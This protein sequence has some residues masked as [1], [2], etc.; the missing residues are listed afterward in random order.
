MEA[1]FGIGAFVVMFGMW[2]IAPHLIKGEA[3]TEE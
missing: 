2:V 3:E 1:V